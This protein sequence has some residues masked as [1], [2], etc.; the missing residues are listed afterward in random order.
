VS[1][2][3]TFTPRTGVHRRLSGLLALSY[4]I[5]MMG[6]GL[7][8]GFRGTTD[9]SD[10]ATAILGAILFLIAAPTSWVFAIEFIEASRLTVI[11][12][13]A[14]TSLPLWYLLGV[15]LAIR[16]ENWPTLVKRYAIFC[17]LWTVLVMVLIVVLAA[18]A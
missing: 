16:A 4:P 11:T 5:A 2:D 15:R 10:L 7:S 8:V 9:T 12:V 6:V 17:G 18:V 13:G 3:I 14:L 1:S